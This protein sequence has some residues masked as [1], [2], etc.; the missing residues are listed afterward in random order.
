MSIYTG[1]KMLLLVGVKL[2]NCIYC[3]TYC[4]SIGICPGL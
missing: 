4:V 1:V 2:N 3:G